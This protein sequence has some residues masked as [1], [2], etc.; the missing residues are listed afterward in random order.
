MLLEII[1]GLVL[2]WSD[3][4]GQFS[5]LSSERWTAARLCFYSPCTRKQ[6]CS[7][8]NLRE[9]GPWKHS[10]NTWALSVAICSFNSPQKRSNVT[11]A[12]QNAR[13]HKNCPRQTQTG[14]E[15]IC[16]SLPPRAVDY[17]WHYLKKKWRV[18]SK[19]TGKPTCLHLKHIV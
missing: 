4:Q 12:Q 17:K 9:N 1:Q 13:F 2:L 18:R 11:P 3:V 19:G 7:E 8:V 15:C 16:K 10:A 5:G 14:M 6:M